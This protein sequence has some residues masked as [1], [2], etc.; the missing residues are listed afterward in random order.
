MFIFRCIFR[1]MYLGGKE[2][3]SSVRFFLFAFSVSSRH[4]SVGRRSRLRTRRIMIYMAFG[5][6]EVLPA[7]T[8]EKDWP[9]D[10][11]ATASLGAWG[12]LVLCA[13]P[14]TREFTTVN[15]CM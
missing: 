14:G 11:I 3:N 10:C 1:C 12:P 15:F 9:S 5:A 7:P 8:Q 6:T 4:Y 13:H 2:I